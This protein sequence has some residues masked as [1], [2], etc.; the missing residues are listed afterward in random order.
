M[1]ESNYTLHKLPEGFIVTSDQKDTIRYLPIV[2][3]K[4]NELEQTADGDDVYHHIKN[5]SKIVI[6][7][8]DQI[9]FNLSEEE[10]KEIGWYDVCSLGEDA[11]NL[12]ILKHKTA[13][14]VLSQSKSWKVEGYWENNKFKLSKIL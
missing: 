11:T 6:A 5:G 8:Q 2:L 14:Q 10:Q 13:N 12:R 9:I 3:T 4:F 7:Q 1:K